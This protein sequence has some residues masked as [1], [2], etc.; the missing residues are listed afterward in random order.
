MTGTAPETSNTC[1]PSPSVATTQV[2][3]TTSSP[4]TQAPVVPTVTP[5]ISNGAAR[6]DTSITRRVGS[7]EWNALLVAPT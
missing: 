5:L 1:S 6:F 7:N 2:V 3:P 4:M